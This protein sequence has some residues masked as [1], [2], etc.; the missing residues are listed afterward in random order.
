MW[1]PKG[2]HDLKIPWLDTK[3]RIGK[4]MNPLQLAALNGLLASLKTIR[5]ISAEYTIHANG[6]FPT[7]S[8]YVVNPLSVCFSLQDDQTHE[9]LPDFPV[10]E[11]RKTGK[12][13]LPTIRSYRE[14]AGQNTLL[15]YPQGNT[16]FDAALFADSHVRK[17]NGAW[18]RRSPQAAT[19]AMTAAIAVPSTG[20]PATLASLPVPV[21]APTGISPETG[22]DTGKMLEQMH[23]TGKEKG[24]K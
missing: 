2:K 13:A 7:V 1:T 22:Q 14:S 4:L 3:K 24:K 20:N 23:G 17:Q 21:L 11:I 12:F 8:N 5:G 16:A 15:P 18:L 10:I 9:N 6:S 19:A